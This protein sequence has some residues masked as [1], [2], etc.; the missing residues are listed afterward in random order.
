[1]NT[2]VKDLKALCAQLPDDAQVWIE[3]PKQLA[4][5]VVIE[6]IDEGVYVARIIESL[7]SAADSK[8]NRLIIFHHG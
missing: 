7:S 5:P 6:E 3:Y 1:M 4:E 2:T 8:Q